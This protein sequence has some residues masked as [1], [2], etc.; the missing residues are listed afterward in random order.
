[1]EFLIGI[2]G[3]GIGSGLMAIVLAALQRKWAKA[4]KK[5]EALKELKSGLA[6]VKSDIGNLRDEMQERAAKDCRVRI[7]R[8]GDE[9]LHEIKHSKEHFNQI[10]LDITEY[11]QYCDTHKD[12]KNNMTVMTT[13]RIKEVYGQCLKDDSFL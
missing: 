1:M 13:A 6:D 10:L 12:F 11:E 2:L 3:A 8:F 9:V 7:L 5:D 4:D